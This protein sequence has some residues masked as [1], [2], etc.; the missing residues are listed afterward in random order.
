M[1]YGNNNNII[2]N[3]IILSVSVVVLTSSWHKMVKQQK[4]TD[5]K[6]ITL[7]KNYKKIKTREI[8]FKTTQTKEKVQK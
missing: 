3:C 1:A 6:H 2:Y 8:K 4:Q 7:A 5:F